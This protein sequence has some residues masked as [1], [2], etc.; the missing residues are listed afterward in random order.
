ML[1]IVDPGGSFTPRSLKSG[2]QSNRPTP[3]IFLTPPLRSVP[4]ELS[5]QCPWCHF[6]SKAFQKVLEMIDATNTEHRSYVPI[7]CVQVR[8]LSGFRLLR[9]QLL[10]YPVHKL[11]V[12]T[13]S[14]ASFS[15]PKFFVQLSS[16]WCR[17][18]VFKLDKL[19][20][21]VSTIH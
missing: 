3:Y 17:P 1:C 18:P 7:W 10:Q 5:N 13:Y 9:G 12:F 4:S 8:G 15:L 2:D 6:V 20:M 11:R 14:L 19:A 21:C 16:Y